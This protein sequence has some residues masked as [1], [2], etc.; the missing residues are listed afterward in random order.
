M[1]DSH[2]TE[3]DKPPLGECDLHFR[4][5][6]FVVTAAQEP[7]ADTGGSVQGDFVLQLLSS[8]TRVCPERQKS[9]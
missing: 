9:P 6:R 1:N 3:S 8:L 7:R 5:N 2:W 4:K